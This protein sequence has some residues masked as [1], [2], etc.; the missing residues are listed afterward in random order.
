MD[1][2]GHF[3]RKK[4]YGIAQDRVQR[5]KINRVGASGMAEKTQRSKNYCSASRIFSQ[6]SHISPGI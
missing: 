1:S 4:I 6:M 5:R 3:N 2:R